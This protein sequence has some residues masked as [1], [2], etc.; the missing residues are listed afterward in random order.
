MI[1]ALDIAHKR[2]FGPRGF[3][4][5]CHTLEGFFILRNVQGYVYIQTG[6]Y[7]YVTLHFPITCQK[8][9]AIVTTR[10]KEVKKKKLG[11]EPLSVES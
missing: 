3:L 2:S 5:S 8:I 1:S 6:T 9:A 4:T 11:Q 7:R 10:K